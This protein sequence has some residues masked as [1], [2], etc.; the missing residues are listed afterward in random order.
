M[1]VHLRSADQFLA[2]S[3]SVAQSSPSFTS[4]AFSVASSFFSSSSKAE[5]FAP[6]KAWAVACDAR[7]EHSCERVDV[8]D[9]ELCLE[10][11]GSWA[12][13]ATSAFSSMANREGKYG[14]RSERKHWK[15]EPTN[16]FMQNLWK[17]QSTLGK[18]RTSRP[19][20]LDEDPEMPGGSVRT[21]HSD[22]LDVRCHR[23]V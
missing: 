21:A 17:F 14:G 22:N 16:P 3:G 18:N 23:G 10:R 8:F 11:L 12:G 7:S 1:E 19:L 6:D 9:S 13:A 15:T 5:S 2:F 4:S 20:H